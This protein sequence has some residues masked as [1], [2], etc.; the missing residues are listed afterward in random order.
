MVQRRENLC[1]ARKSRATI[2]IAQ[3]GWR[4]DFNRNVPTKC[5]VAGAIHLAHP[6]GA[7]GRHDFIRSE[8]STGTE[9]HPLSGTARIVTNSSYKTSRVA[10]GPELMDLGEWDIREASPGSDGERRTFSIL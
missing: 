2:G 3:K 9:G 5:R 8:P 1:F 6:A 4:Q 7:Y 10:R